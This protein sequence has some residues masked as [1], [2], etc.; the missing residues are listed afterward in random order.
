MLEPTV[1]EE[2]AQIDVFD[3]ERLLGN[4]WVRVGAAVAVGFM[5]GYRGD[6]QVVRTGVRLMLTTAARALMHDALHR[7]GG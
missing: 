3:P 2:R 6:S 7:A 5:A 1:R 4:P